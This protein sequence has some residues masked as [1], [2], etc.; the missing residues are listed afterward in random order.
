MVLDA[1]TRSRAAVAAAVLVQQLAAAP[2]RHEHVAVP[3]DAHEATSRPP[4]VACS[5]E[6]SAALG[7]QR[8]AVGGV[9]DVAARDDPAV[10]DQ[11][12]RP[13]REPSTA[14]RRGA[15]PRLRLYFKLV[16]VLLDPRGHYDAYADARGLWQVPP[17]DDPERF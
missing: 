15:S 16:P 4:P 17:K 12:R 2:A 13:D 5:S 9:L 3:F 7:A 6:T 8:D 11:R 10:V 14:R 1:P